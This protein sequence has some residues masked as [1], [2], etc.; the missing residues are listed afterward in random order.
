MSPDGKHLA[1]SADLGDG[2]YALVVYRIAGMQSTTMLRLPRYELPM[3]IAWVSDRRLVIGKGRKLGSLEE[4]MPMGEIIATDLDGSNQRY[5]YGYLQST[6]NAGLERGFGYIEGLPSRRNGHFYMRRLSLDSRHSMLYDVDA[7]TTTHRLMADIDVPDLRFVLD[8]DGVAHYAYGSD[9]NDNPLLFRR[10]GNG[11]SP[12][13]QVRQ[14]ATD[15]IRA[16]AGPPL[17]LVQRRGWPCS[18]GDHRSRRPAA[19]RACVGPVLQRG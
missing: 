1:V 11:W 12:M 7:N 4:P 19:Q 17:W 13:S 15:R 14:L 3:R 6:R 18:P 5:V 2:N 9:D 10:S 16:T 8:H